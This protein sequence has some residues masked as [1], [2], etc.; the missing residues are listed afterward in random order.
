MSYRVFARKYRPQTFE[1][2]VGQEHITRTL[3]N[4]ITAERLA[5]AYLFV[6][7]RGIGKT[8]TAR[9]LAKALNCERGP[10]T[11]PCGECDACREIAEGNSLDVLEIDGASNNSVDSVRELRENAAYAPA[12]GPYKIYLIDEV[13]M[14][15]TAA[16]NALLKTL[17][18]PPPHV[19]FIFATTEAQKVPATITSRCQRF[20]LRRIPAELIAA[21][22]QAI[23]K[24]ESVELGDEAAAAVAKGAD[25][26]LRDAESMLDQLVA[27]CGESISEDDVLTV[28]GFTARETVL[29]LTARLFAL[30]AGAAL[31]LVADQAE[32]GRDLSR[33]L[34]DVIAH[35]R[36]LLVTKVQAGG[37]PEAAAQAE[38][39]SREKLIILLEHFAE[40]EGRLRWATDKRLYLDVA[41]IKAVHLLDQTSLSDVI[42]TLTAIGEGGEAVR[43][44]QV[45][46]QAKEQLAEQRHPLPERKPVARREVPLAQ[47]KP[48]VRKSVPQPETVAAPREVAVE[49]TAPREDA[50]VTKAAEAPNPMAEASE[51]E[52][53]S[54]VEKPPSGGEMTTE[55]AAVWAALSTELA[56]ESVIQLGWLARGEF[57]RI[58]GSRFQV[59]FPASLEENTVG[60]IWNDLRKK[61]ERR[62]KDALGQRVEF[63]PTFSSEMSEPVVPEEEAA[64]EVDP[65]TATK[66][67]DAAEPELTAEQVMEKFRDDPLIRKAIEVFRA[68]IETPAT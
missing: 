24:N 21:H 68:E 35:L 40:V 65:V 57:E 45:S 27:F 33:L 58:D 18:E 26:G 9:I 16:F 34:G 54:A 49:R 28:F 47:E 29:D 13:H 52:R 43:R 38:A 60:M 30:D 41:V 1:Q 5:Q 64:P 17:E 67:D 31:A 12:R 50:T 55:P 39:V 15:S 23:A 36:D 63:A 56:G 51:P 37:D 66:S 32:A 59:R 62:L 44:P 14:L 48:E 19:K 42:D 7:P 46:E 25:G 3:Q 20:D 11:E 61:L 6:G 8:S 10:T 53:E 22:L 2:V 4:A